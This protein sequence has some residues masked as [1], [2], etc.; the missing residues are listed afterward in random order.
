MARCSSCQNDLMSVITATLDPE[1]P[2]R[3][4]A[5]VFLCFLT[6]AIEGI[7]L[8]SMGIAAPSLG[9][10]FGLSRTELGMA[11]AA[12][13]LGLFFG[14][15]IGGRIADVWGRRV[16]LLLA[17]VVFGAFQLGTAWTTG[18][19][20][21]TVLRVLCGVGLGG[22][23]PNLI[24]LTAEASGGRN[25]ILNVVITIAGMPVGGTV[26][27]LIGF[28]AGP[29]GDWR[30]VFYVG[31][32]A[33]LV[34][35]PILAV[36]LPESQLF[37]AAKAARSGAPEPV[38]R[39]LFGGGRRSATLL[40]WVAYF[41]T[42][43]MTYLLLN[44]LPVL[45]GARGFTKTQALLIQILFNIGAAGGSVLLGL[46]MQ[47]RPNRMLLFVC[48]A[49]LALS[50]LMIAQV[51]EELALAAA[52]AALVGAFLLGAQYILYGIAPDYYEIAI[53]GTGTGAAVAAG[54]LGSVAGPYLAGWLLGAGA[55]DAHVLEAMLPVTAVAAAAGV[56]LMFTRR[57]RPK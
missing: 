57:L 25:N 3:V 15:F 35:A 53:R 56:G 48:Y 1:R 38:S 10:E 5:T 6:A 41:F 7:D 23:M 22:A 13:P 11:V 44:W 52:A 29:H 12:S 54:R 42:A 21:L 19:W 9:P 14:A 46:W 31:G 33:P 49:G 32:I 26:A 39:V 18:F 47:R 4:F 16:A 36:A 30:L 51:G 24:A 37:Q 45:M 20:S 50:L 43:F 2:Q 27:S 34:L 28:L 40:L 8:Q 17:T 55:S